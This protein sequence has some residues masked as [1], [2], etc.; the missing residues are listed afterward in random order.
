MSSSVSVADVLRYRYRF[1]V[2]FNCTWF[3]VVPGPEAGREL[4]RL[5]TGS[6]SSA[7]TDTHTKLNSVL[8]FNRTNHSNKYREFCCRI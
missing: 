7:E 3:K 2:K 5:Y 4:V 1:L 6:Q 8:S